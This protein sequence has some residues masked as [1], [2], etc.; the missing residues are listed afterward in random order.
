MDAE[1]G[2]KPVTPAP[3]APNGLPTDWNF[4]RLYRSRSTSQTTGRQRLA[5]DVL[6]MMSPAKKKHWDTRSTP[7]AGPPTW[8]GRTVGL[9]LQRHCPG[10]DREPV[11]LQT[12]RYYAIKSATEVPIDRPV[13]Q[14]KG[15]GVRFT[16]SVRAQRTAERNVAKGRRC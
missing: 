16:S 9:Y 5:H 4:E 2:A 13:G 14:R 11:H 8:R 7:E 10:L 3:T 12:A 15:C 1:C 6:D